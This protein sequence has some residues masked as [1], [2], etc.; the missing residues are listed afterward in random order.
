MYDFHVVHGSGIEAVSC[1]CSPEV[2]PRLIW[3]QQQWCHNTPTQVTC[4]VVTVT[5][6]LQQ[7]VPD[8]PFNFKAH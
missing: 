7:V 1:Q 8:L 2:G 3:S 4:V 5:L 6:S